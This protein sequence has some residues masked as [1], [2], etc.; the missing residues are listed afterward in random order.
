[1]TEFKTYKREPKSGG[2]PGSMVIFLHGFGANGQDLINIGDEWA[3]DLPD[4][5]FLS[6]DAPFPC[7][8]A[9]GMPNSFQWFSLQSRDPH[10]MLRGAEQAKPILNNYIDNALKEY[11]LK[12]KNLALVG[13]S[14]GTMMSLHTA[15]R[16]TNKIAGVLGYSGLLLGN[17]A[18]SKHNLP[19][20]LIHGEGD[21][22]VP[23][24]AY[25]HA[26]E[27]LVRAGFEVSGH[28]TPGLGHGI[29]SKGLQSGLTFL[30][31]ILS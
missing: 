25:H 3:Q 5:V 7:E 10:D 15:P 9:F 19:V 28:T 2:Q 4:T 20:H 13:F 26:R 29:D 11:D 6:P 8:L 14:Q 30:K 27:E 18:E 22:V 24:T 12:D 16:R 1:M 31:E 23:V 17:V 21:D